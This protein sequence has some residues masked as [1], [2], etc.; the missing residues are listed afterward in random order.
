M[1]TRNLVFSRSHVAG[2]RAEMTDLIT[3]QRPSAVPFSA[4]DIA[5]SSYT[6]SGTM[7]LLHRISYPQAS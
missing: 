3:A 7:E 1:S 6:E 2:R 4:L 5:D